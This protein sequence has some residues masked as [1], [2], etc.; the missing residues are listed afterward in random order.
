MQLTPRFEEALIYTLEVHAGQN[1]K[2]KEVP[3]FSH[4]MGVA[5]LVMEN[6]GDE[7]QAIA[8]LLHDAPEDRGGRERLDDIRRRFGDRVAEIVE[9]CTDTFEK[10]KPAWR[11][12][13]E[14]YL[15]H[16][17]SAPR[18]VRL[19][20]L[21]DKLYNSQA[22]LAD[23]IETGPAVWDRFTSSKEDTLWYYRSLVEIFNDE[24]AN[25]GPMAVQLKWVVNKIDEIARKTI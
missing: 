3:Y 5:A 14:K 13:K 16:L 18:Y 21:A 23:L 20:S 25:D 10:P 9:G 4:L 15:A 7:D 8:G 19:V 24:Q 12:R 6:G 17:P 22:I 2:G 11:K 1:R